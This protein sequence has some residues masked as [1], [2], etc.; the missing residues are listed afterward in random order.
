MKATRLLSNFKQDI[1]VVFKVF[2]VCLLGL[3]VS[4]VGSADL[5]MQSSM[6]ESSF[7]L[8]PLEDFTAVYGEPKTFGPIGAWLIAQLGPASF[9]QLFPTWYW[10]RL[11]LHFAWSRPVICER[12]DVAQCMTYGNASNGLPERLQGI[13]WQD[14]VGIPEQAISTAGIWDPENRILSFG[15]S[16]NR[17]W[18][19][20][21]SNST[22]G[23]SGFHQSGASLMNFHSLIESHLR[24]YFNE[25]LTFGQVI[26]VVPLL[27]IDFAL[28]PTLVNWTMTW[29][30]KEGY[31][32]RNSSAFGVSEQLG[33]YILKPIVD[34]EGQPTRFFDDWLKAR[35]GNHIV[36]NE[37][38]YSLN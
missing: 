8:N 31:W 38:A 7:G 26:I 21:E 17:Q 36:V 24:I 28:P 13:L 2:S 35:D 14:G 10:P 9:D 33:N 18:A 29:D 27:G 4:V 19:Y 20:W 30:P 15:P 5:E 34:G 32:I 23:P 25:E 37:V 12:K 1:V 16:N 22:F 11:A 6:A 3:H